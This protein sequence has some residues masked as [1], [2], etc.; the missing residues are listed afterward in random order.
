MTRV[1]KWIAALL[2]TV[3]SGVGLTWLWRR[4]TGAA[5]D[6]SRELAQDRLDAAIELGARHVEDA[7]RTA[8]EEVQRGMVEHHSL[9]D[10]LRARLG[11]RG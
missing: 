4:R 10:Y 1:W 2:A 7:N 6:R 8:T 5:T 9:A 3:A 11:K